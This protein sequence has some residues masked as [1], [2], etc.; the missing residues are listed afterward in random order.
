MLKKVVI[1]YNDK[2]KRA[3]EI[4]PRLKARLRKKGVTIVHPLRSGALPAGIDLAIALGGDGTMLKVARRIAPYNIPL[5]GVNMGSLGFLAEVDGHRLDRAINNIFREGLQVERRLMLAVKVGS[6]N[7]KGSSFKGEA[8]NECVIRCGDIARVI[9]L[10]VWIGTRFLTR[11]VGDGLIVAT[12]TG[13]TAY[14]LAASGPIVHPSLDLL[15]I[16]PVC[17]HTLAQRPIIVGADETIKIM[18]Q[19]HDHRHPGIVSL[20]GQINKNLKKGDLITV[21]RA[22]HDLLTIISSA[23]DYYSILREKMGWGKR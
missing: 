22:P 15:L 11:Y 9:V 14:S 18:I 20:D 6:R 10:D 16:T 7:T 1:F 17:P 12:P 8:L 21:T 23:R 2:K 19:K 4:M 3:R 13:S 5:Y